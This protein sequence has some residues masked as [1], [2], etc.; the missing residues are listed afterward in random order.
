MPST[1][2]TTDAGDADPAPRRISRLRL[3]ERINASTSSLI[4]NN[5][6]GANDDSTSGETAAPDSHTGVR[7]S[8]DAAVEKLKD[9]VSHRRS[10]EVRRGSND[11]SAATGSR[12][13][14][15]LVP[16]RSRRRSKQ[17]EDANLVSQAL[18]GSVEGLSLSGNASESSL[19]A[20]S[21]QSSLLTDG[22]SDTER[23]VQILRLYHCTACLCWSILGDLGQAS[24]EFALEKHLKRYI[25]HS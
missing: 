23:Y 21:D 5:S 15:T 24:L 18:G 16:G 6:S 11:S 19:V 9:K 22:Y 10:S 3:R 20:G 1:A 12:R 13:L 4:S 14:S 17:A 25:H 2:A 8:M 7:N